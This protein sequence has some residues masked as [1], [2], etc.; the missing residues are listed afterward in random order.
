MSFADELDQ[1]FVGRRDVWAEGYPDKDNPT[2][3]RYATRYEPLTP[4]QI[5]AHTQG[6]IC[7]GIYPILPDNT[8]QW[9][10]VDFDA[11]KVDGVVVDDPFPYACDAAELQAKAFEAAGLQVYVARSRSGTG[12]HVWG[13]L[14][15][16]VPAAI[17]RQALAPL[18]TDGEILES[19]DRM[20]PV[21][22]VL[23]D[24]KPLGNLISMPFFGKA[25]VQGN[26]VFIDRVTRQP[27]LAKEWLAALERNQPAV[28]ERLAAKAPKRRQVTPGSP[29]VY[30]AGEGDEINYG[31]LV[32]GA[33]KVLSP[34]GCKFFRHCATARNG[35]PEPIWYAGIQ[36]STHFEHGRDLAHVLSKDDPRYEEG[37]VDA[38]FD[39]AMSNPR[40]G[41]QWI[42]DNYPALAC[43][44]C[45]NKAPHRLAS[46]SILQLA[47]GS[48]QEMRRAGSFAGDLNRIKR[49]QKGTEVLG[50]P[51]GIAGLDDYS[52]LR[53]S[54]FIAIGGAP[55]MGKTHMLVNATMAAAREVP[56]VRPPMYAFVFSAETAERAL[57][58][59]FLA[60][61][62]EVDSRLLTGEIKRPI[63]PQEWKQIEWAGEHLEQMPVYLDYTSLSADDVLLQIET[64]L[65]RDRVSLDTPLVVFFDYL[66]FGAK[67]LEDTTEYDRIS[68]LST[69]FKFTSKIL[70][71]PVVVFSQLKRE[72][73]GSDAP[74]MTWWKNS[75]RI[76]SDIDVGIIITGE[77]MTGDWAPRR[78]TLVKQREGVANVAL[79]FSLQQ[80]FGL[81]RFVGSPEHN[82][83]RAPLWQDGAPDALGA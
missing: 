40:I 67:M 81:W 29:R 14:E 9:F 19:R 45:E 38:K 31:P 36:I 75:G 71:H 3:Y 33:L 21:Q 32:T 82:V 73:E 34:Y 43:G 59:R 41:C 24:S 27:L 78:L 51:W 4:A 28:L 52:R 6:K 46:K 10:A 80:T 1:L 22:D 66:Q 5:Q 48:R 77:R 61:L 39:Q 23:T 54:E 58:T 17:V 18:L 56:G 76:E 8:V 7:V 74:D 2:K 72:A 79:D 49:I 57:R 63:T 44:G 16:P 47:R 55:S 64:V 30:Q 20:F 65:L 42:H 60:H 50:Q 68:R 15:R 53:G 12:A 69:E 83:T 35:L 13:F 26:S 37:A 25:A 62:A 11:P 70:G